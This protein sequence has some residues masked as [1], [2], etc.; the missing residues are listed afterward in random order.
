MI[1]FYSA[2]KRDVYVFKIQYIY[3]ERESISTALCII[4]HLKGVYVFR[5][6][7]GMLEINAILSILSFYD[8]RKKVP[9]ETSAY[10]N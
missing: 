7:L 10:A 1:N 3:R 4:Q 9:V 2:A 5:S 6:D 8:K